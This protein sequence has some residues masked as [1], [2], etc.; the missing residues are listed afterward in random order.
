MSLW[1][2]IALVAALVVA[3][4]P[5]SLADTKRWRD[6]NDAR[7]P[8]DIASISHAHRMGPKGVRQ[9]VHTVRFHRAW[10]VR[11][12]K[13]K[14]FVHLQIDRPGHRGSPQERTVWI[15]YRKGRLIATMY[16][17]LGDPPKKL[18]RVQL[19]RPS[20]RIVKVAFP[21]TLLK[22]RG[23]ERYKWNAIAYVEGGHDLCPGRNGWT[24]LAPNPAGGRR[25]VRHVL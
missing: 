3:A 14:G 24:D 5:A 13:H 6:G 16:N 9:L 10:P 19:W 8:L 20:R 15:T 25:Y 12:L 1:T 17:T 2:R 18:A 22:R 7:G 23:L 11:K 21:K 4:A